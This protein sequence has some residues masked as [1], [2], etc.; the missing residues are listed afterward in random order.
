MQA[1]IRGELDELMIRVALKS[2]SETI[3]DETRDFLQAVVRD[4]QRV[5]EQVSKLKDI[6]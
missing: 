1:T 6:L 2:A 5:R 3:S 4:I